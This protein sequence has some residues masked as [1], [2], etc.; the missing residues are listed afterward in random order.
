MELIHFIN[1]DDAKREEDNEL[2]L[3]PTYP[4]KTF[5]QQR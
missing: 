3:L 5:Q 4:P 1:H 2:L